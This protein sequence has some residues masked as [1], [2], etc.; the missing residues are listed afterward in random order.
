MQGVESSGMR[1]AS[2]WRNSLISDQKL[3]HPRRKG[4]VPSP[5]FRLE[6]CFYA[7]QFEVYK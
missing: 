1:V 4:L 7:N 6:F 5:L 2:F 3:T